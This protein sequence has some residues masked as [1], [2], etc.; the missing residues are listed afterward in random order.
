[1][2]KLLCLLCILVCL[3]LTGCSALDAYEDILTENY[4]DAFYDKIEADSDLP[5]SR[6]SYEKMEKAVSSQN[7]ADKVKAF[8]DNMP[9][10]L[11]PLADPFVEWSQKSAETS[12]SKYTE[13]LAK[14]EIYQEAKLQSLGLDEESLSKTLVPVIV[15]VLLLLGLMF[16]LKSLKRAKLKRQIKENRE[17][18]EAALT[19]PILTHDPLSS[20]PASPNDFTYLPG[21]ESTLQVN[22][23]KLLKR[24]CEKLGLNYNEVLA[25]HNG[26]AQAAWRET[27]LMDN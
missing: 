10:F 20:S 16:L 18:R 9:D 12:A 13:A 27:W 14:D 3:P 8:Q 21:R 2:R 11:E 1:M 26:D 15:I 23:Q 22:Y 25:K 24:N 7:F 4:V 17:M 5:M 19:T 6:D